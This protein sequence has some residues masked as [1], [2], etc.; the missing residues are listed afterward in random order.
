[1]GEDQPGPFTSSRRNTKRIRI[2]LSIIALINCALVIFQ[3][4]SF[5][6]SGFTEKLSILWPF[7]LIYFIEILVIGLAV[8]PVS[9]TVNEDSHPFWAAIP[10]ICAGLLLAFVILGAWT[11]GF[12]LVPAMILF[13]I[14]GVL[15]DRDTSGEIPLHII[16][17]IAAAIAQVLF[18]Y[19][20]RIFD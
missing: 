17:F 6:T 7:P 12:F 11:I 16:Y 10:W 9:F 15:G 4:A 3:F 13:I 14:I 18:I 5:E 8:L 2:V 1:M 19:V 20:M